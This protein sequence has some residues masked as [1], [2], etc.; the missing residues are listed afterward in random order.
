MSGNDVLKE[1]Y[2]TYG[3]WIET[4]GDEAPRFLNN[5][6]ANLLSA[7]KEKVEFY[8]IRLRQYENNYSRVN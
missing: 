2:T 3:E 4:A 8:R 5:L 6:L 1:V 7:E